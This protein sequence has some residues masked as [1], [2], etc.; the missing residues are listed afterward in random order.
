MNKMWWKIHL[1]LT[2][3]LQRYMEWWNLFQCSNMCS[4]KDHSLNR[5]SRVSDEGLKN[6]HYQFFWTSQYCVHSTHT[7]HTFN[8][9]CCAY[10]PHVCFPSYPQLQYICT[11]M[12]KKWHFDHLFKHKTWYCRAQVYL[13]RFHFRI[14][15]GVVDVLILIEFDSSCF[16]VYLLATH[17][18]NYVIFPQI[19]TNMDDN[20]RI[21]GKWQIQNYSM[22]LSLYCAA[23]R[24]LLAGKTRVFPVHPAAH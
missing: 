7:L 11:Q 4:V 14:N 3:E 20:R 2:F 8:K 21:H 24:R 16:P 1:K 13:F 17:F 15:N 19:T 23:C 6:K 18:R 12:A 9:S 22:D 5:P 10:S